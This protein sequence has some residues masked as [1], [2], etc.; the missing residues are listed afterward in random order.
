MQRAFSCQFE[1]L[2]TLKSDIRTA[3]RRNF[4]NN[5]PNRVPKTKI[6]TLYTDECESGDQQQG[7]N[8]P[9]A[10]KAQIRQ[11]DGT[12]ILTV[13]SDTSVTTKLEPFNFW[14]GMNNK[15]SLLYTLERRIPANDLQK[16]LTEYY[17]EIRY[18]KQALTSDISLEFSERLYSRWEWKAV[19]AF[20]YCRFL[21]IRGGWTLSDICKPL[22]SV[23]LSHR[24]Y[25][26]RTPIQ[27]TSTCT[28]TFMR[29]EPEV[30]ISN[31]SADSSRSSYCTLSPCTVH[32]YHSV[33]LS[34]ARLMWSVGKH[35][36]LFKVCEQGDASNFRKSASTLVPSTKKVND[37][38]WEKRFENLLQVSHREVQS[39]FYFSSLH[40]DTPD[41][42]Q[43]SP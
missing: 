14:D 27:I 33:G 1:K 31:F 37:L 39:L 29:K 24:L 19:E 18:L 3:M 40:K 16:Q 22:E 34:F 25:W 41:V 12:Q 32:L 2:A 9:F 38:S 30:A 13:N 4:D 6:P 7:V 21:K 15:E 5:Y 43:S 35:Y 36:T 8:V 17:L 26:L 11:V 42:A 20:D 28:R 23:V 10:I